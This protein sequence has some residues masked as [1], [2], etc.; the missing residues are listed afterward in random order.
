MT[1]PIPVEVFSSELQPGE[2]I[3]WS[4]QPNLSVIFHRED[5]I[6]IPFGFMWGGF[7]IFWLLAASGM[8][9][10]WQNKPNH[11]FQL[12]GIIWG[13]PFVVV[14]QYMIWGRFVHRRWKKKRTYYALT[15]R[16]ALI[17]E[18]GFR[19]RTSS[20]AFFDTVP[21]VDKRVRQD[22][23]GSISFG[24]PVTDEWQWG[25]NKPPR[26]PT[27][28][29]VENADALYQTVLRLQDQA[30]KSAGTPQTRWPT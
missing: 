28:D 29:D 2:T 18:Y 15:N 20:S 17:V 6:A 11:P 7:A 8:W 22:G 26:P 5:W 12:F 13:T 1:T 24:G 10:I 3:E 14:G 9:D 25:K 16:R 21:T 23:I 30:R 27:F 19:N 4:G